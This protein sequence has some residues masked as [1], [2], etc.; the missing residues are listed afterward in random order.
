M[1]EMIDG[2]MTE[3]GSC[4]VCCVDLGQTPE[5]NVCERCLLKAALRSGEQEIREEI[6]QITTASERAAYVEAVCSDDPGLRKRLLDW[7]PDLDHDS[8]TLVPTSPPTTTSDP[9]PINGRFRLLQKLGEGGFG[10]V[11]LAQQLAPVQRQVAVKIL[12]LGMDTLQATETKSVVARFEAERQALARMDHPNIAKVFDAGVT[13]QGRPFFVMELVRGI[14][15]TEYCDQNRLTTKQRLNLF[16]EVCQ[17]IQHAHQ[18]GIIHRDIKP[19]NIL[20]T[21]LNGEPVPKVIDFGIAK[22]TEGRLTDATIYTQLQQFIGTPA[23]MSP[24][25][26]EMSGLDIDTRSDIYSLGVLLYEILTGRTPFDAKELNAAGFDAMRR[27]IREREPLRPSTRLATLSAEERATTAKGHSADVPKLLHQVKGD[28][29]WIVMRCL[30]KDRT[31]RYD[32]ANGLAMDIKRH[33]GHEPVVARPPSTAYRFSKAWRRNRV[34]FAGAGAVAAAIVAGAGVSLWQAA[35]ATRAKNQAIRL[36]LD[37]AQEARLAQQERNKAQAAQ[38]LA[39][40]QRQ[41]AVAGE[42]LAQQLLYTADMRLVQQDWDQNNVRGV[43]RLLSETRD[44]QDRGFEWYYWQRLMH[45]E[46]QTLRGHTATIL[47]VAYSPDGSRLVTGS[48]DKTAKV[49][50]AASGKQ[51]LTLTG[52]SDSINSAVFTPDGRRIVTASTDGTAKVWDADTGRDL[53]TFNGHGGSVHSVS[54]S[55]DGQQVVTANSDRTAK[56]WDLASGH[57]LIVLKGHTAQVVAV[58]FSPDGRR[59]VTGSEDDTAV[60]WDVVSAQPLLALKGH[61][62]AVCSVAFSSDGTQIVTGGYDGTARIWDATTGRQ[63]SVLTGHS[64]RI[65]CARFS[66]DGRRA[67]TG[68]DDQTAK[69]WDTTTGQELFSLKGHLEVIW[70]VAFSPNSQDIATVSGDETAKIWSATGEQE[71]LTFRQHSDRVRSAAF[72]PDGRRIVTGS[73]DKRAE[74]WNAATGQELLALKGHEGPVRSVA[75]SRD[76]QRIV[77]ASSDHTAKVWSAAN[78]RE[79]LTLRGHGDVV[80]RATF[81]PDGQR[82]ATASKDNT[83]RIWNSIDGA[84]L[85]T[86]KAHTD[87]VMA[88]AFSPDGTSVVTGSSDGTVRLWDAITGTQRFILKESH[89]PV[90]AVAYSPDGTR[91]ATGGDGSTARVWDASDGK[92]L[93][94]LVGHKSWLS[95]VAYSPDGNRIV[96]GGDDSTVRVWDAHNGRELLILKG[97]TRGV[98]CVAFSP[99][100][101]RIVTGGFDR[102]AKVW[103]AAT[104][105]QAAA[106]QRD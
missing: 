63:R 64:D 51:L 66:A 103:K 86:L 1:A 33:L 97:H 91:I 52:H 72:S 105:D 89:A 95:S 70:S 67:V 32:T 75:F 14:R 73:D 90:L 61:T 81:S 20:V 35:V 22:A 78:G 65:R 47:S 104:A 100:G 26:A 45:L 4:T 19:T 79:L 44:N 87:M 82:I 42:R 83:A 39:D 98:D 7:L 27:I 74:V 94:T 88:V 17:A 13:E 106:W 60:V 53:L 76:G 55:P 101:V 50:D 102:T 54:C 36:E 9:Q 38:K 84:V 80:T 43:H 99:E 18:K 41:R 2:P 15:I 62:D 21:L 49:W 25:Q 12:K 28:L 16:I 58:A 68:S 48:K 85:L 59:V 93:L 30:E 96:T 57:E 11:Y 69:V 77:T 31:R 71:Y 10:T 23:Y 56:V 46:L 40:E 3:T 24:E 34:L 37:R 29:D 6:L 92:L 8:P 5:N